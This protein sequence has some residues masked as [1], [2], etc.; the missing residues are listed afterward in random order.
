MTTEKEN[1]NFTHT[2]PRVVGPL[3]SGL[4]ATEGETDSE[5]MSKG[6]R[7]LG[8]TLK[9][10]SVLCTSL[11]ALKQL[12][13]MGGADKTGTASPLNKNESKYQVQSPRSDA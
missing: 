7:I 5:G 1:S 2:V 4:H 10:I 3:H 9:R 13:Y 6:D 12:P 8:Q 11:P